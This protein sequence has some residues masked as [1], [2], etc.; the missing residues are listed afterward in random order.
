MGANTICA[1]AIKIIPPASWAALDA[2][3]KRFD[4]Y[5]ALVFTSTNA[6]EAFFSRAGSAV[7]PRRLFAVG[8][9]TALALGDRGWKATGIPDVFNAAELA[10]RM[11]RV[12]GWTILCP[13][14]D[15]AREVLPRL[16]RRG[17]AR[18]DLPIVYRTVP[19]RA[20]QSILRRAVRRGVDWV[21]FTSPST[22]ASF[23]GALGKKEALRFLTQARA[24]SIGPVTSAALRAHGVVP[25]AE[26]SPSTAEGLAA[27]IAKRSMS[28]PPAA[29][30]KTLITALRA[31][32]RE[33]R[34]GFGKAKVSYKGRAN[35]VTEADLAAEEAILSTILARFPD[36]DFL[37]EER[38]PR[39]TGSDYLWVIDPIDGTL[40]YSHGF[41]HSGASIA[42]VR[43]GVVVAGGVYD[44]FRDELFLA[45][46]G[47][48]ATLNGRIIR[49]GPTKRLR[50]ALLI[51][52]FA[53]DRHLR[54]A[55]YAGFVREFLKRAADLRRSGSA[56]LDLAWL[57][58]GRVDGFWEFHLSPWDVAAGK[59]LVEE[60]G[61]RIS[62]FRNKPW[63]ADPRAWGRQTL[64]SNGRIHK[65]M[66]R[67][68][69]QKLAG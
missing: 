12:R 20:G 64:A 65:S 43:R 44:P 16:L 45:E 35:P 53:Y 47:R 69:K 62:D 9:A 28:I 10:R 3:L 19:D 24:A 4:A 68:L 38:A 57:A 11:G 52:G 2:C 32:G 40:N 27:A 63:S 22:A 33:M 23:F 61:G 29:L 21:T 26:A 1:P 7:L 42:V 36:H 67:V 25:S 58:A 60:A 13:R 37:T 17:G 56:A 8:R 48:G 14:A 66:L 31:A 59:L 50:E 51:T 18:I 34:R 41:P 5:D 15:Q 6:V 54:A 30:R 49:V 55:R 46:R 39:F